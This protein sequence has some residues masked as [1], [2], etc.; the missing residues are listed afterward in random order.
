MVLSVS[1][2]NPNPV[3]LI[4]LILLN[5]GLLMATF[6]FGQDNVVLRNGDE[7]PAK[8]LEVNQTGLKFRKSANPDGPV[9]TAFLREVM[10]IKY[11]NGTEDTFLIF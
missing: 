7:I 1:H 3:I 4:L 10:L 11:A 6:A 5:T 9:C 2:S 8:V